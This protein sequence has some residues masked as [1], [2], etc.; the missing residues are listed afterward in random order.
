MK[1]RNIKL[2][3]AFFIGFAVLGYLREFF[4][5]HLNIIMYSKYYQKPPIL[6]IPASM[7][8]FNAFSYEFLY[9]AK[10]V[11]TLLF[12]VAFLALNYFAIKKLTTNQQLL[13]ILIYIY[14]IMGTL[15]L[16]SMLYGYFVNDRLQDDEYTLSRWLMGVAQS[17]IICLILLASEKLYPKTNH[18]D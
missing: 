2:V 5:V 1:R 17:P 13:K 10:Y 11:F 15:A 18:H 14:V 12:A 9:Y 3:I 16:L 4:F 8:L 7:S 6:P